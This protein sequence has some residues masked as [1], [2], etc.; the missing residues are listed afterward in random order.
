MY[1]SVYPSVCLSVRL[2]VH[3]TVGPPMGPS[4]SSYLTQ[5]GWGYCPRGVDMHGHRSL[6]LCLWTTHE[7]LVYMGMTFCFCGL[8]SWWYDLDHACF[9]WWWVH[10]LWGPC[11]LVH[12]SSSAYAAFHISSGTVSNTDFENIAEVACRQLGLSGG[13]ANAGF[14]A[15]V[16]NV[17]MDDVFCHGNEAQLS[18]CYEFTWGCNHC[19]HSEDVGIECGWT[20]IESPCTEEKENQIRIMGEV[21]A[22]RVE[23][24]HE[25]QWGMLHKIIHCKERFLRLK[26]KNN[27]KAVLLKV[28]LL[29]GYYNHGILLWYHK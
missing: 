9:W 28:I 2:S 17:W 14:G 16:G 18:D 15:G 5:I 29:I 11:G 22:G 1:P 27:S 25:E 12:F 23:I 21:N 20:E 26:D 24:C 6:V 4:Y 13:Q 7:G 3:L 19:D 10:P 8:C